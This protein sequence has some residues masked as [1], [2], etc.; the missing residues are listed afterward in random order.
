MGVMV[1]RLGQMRAAWYERNGA[2]REVLQVGD[3]EV[4]PVGPGE[5]KIRLAWSGV[6]P[7]DV[8]SRSGATR[9]I[10]FA[11]VIPHSD[12]AG[13]IEEVGAGVP[14]SRVGERVW[15]WS[16][17]WQRPF[18]TCAEYVVVPS[19]QA[20]RLPDGIPLETGACLGIPALTAHRALFADG[21]IQGQTVLVTGGAGAVGHTAV[22]LGKWG[23]GH[24]I[25]TVSSP[26]KADVARECGADCVIN[27]RD[28]D[29]VARVLDFTGGRPVD[30]VV[31]VGLGANLA[32]DLAVLKTNGVVATYASDGGPLNPELPF[33]Q[34]LRSAITLRFVY[35]YVLPKT[36]LTQCLS[37][38][39]A[40]LEAG[41]LKPR[42]AARLPLSEVV[43]AH[44]LQESGQAI[45]NILVALS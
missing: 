39:T 21:P 34:L 29:V 24:V 43:S 26:Q 19:E 17:Q 40:A 45:G 9:P 31:D 41:A 12:G 38:T 30:R 25:A 15:T 14:S 35:M 23:G 42:I 10:S 27:Y 18:G 44:E 8:K 5:V 7:S 32:T 22:Q 33:Q 4:P 13:V 20:V 16:A 37:D 28:E 36:A 2:A 3:M 6:N 11:R 1:I